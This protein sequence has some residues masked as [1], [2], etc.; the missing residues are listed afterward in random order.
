MLI[1]NISL[2]YVVKPLLQWLSRRIILEFNIKMWYNFQARGYVVK[3]YAVI[4]A[5]GSGKRFGSDLPKQFAQINGKTLIELSVEAF[6]QCL[7]I[8]S[9]ILVVNS[10]YKQKILDIINNNNYKKILKIVEGGKERKDS[11]YNG[12]FAIEDDE[13]N[14]LIHDCARP[15]VTQDIIERCVKALDSHNAVTTAI[16]SSDTVVV[17]KNDLLVEI[18][19]RSTL[20]R[21]QTP[22]GF[23][24]SLIKKAHLLSANDSNFTDDCGLI[25]KNSLSDVFVVEGSE[26]N[27]KVTYPEDIK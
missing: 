5:S 17:V 27:I 11:S 13:A 1:C 3:N 6:E 7:F 2:Q 4:L 15:F 25:L 9:I 23:K 12:V 18:P 20:R 10:Q 24:L 8:D 16:K 14:V 22:Q 21:V 19:D 26:S